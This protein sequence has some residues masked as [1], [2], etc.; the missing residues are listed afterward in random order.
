MGGAITN[1]NREENGSCM[2]WH[3][4]DKSEYAHPNIAVSEIRFFFRRPGAA[5]NFLQ[6]LSLEVWRAVTPRHRLA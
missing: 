2:A 5:L 6:E 3:A 1:S 4:L